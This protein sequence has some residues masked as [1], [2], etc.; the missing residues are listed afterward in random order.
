MKRICKTIVAIVATAGMCLG[1]YGQPFGVNPA[2]FNYF[3]DF[4][5]P[6]VK[7]L[8]QDLTPGPEEAYI[9]HGKPGDWGLGTRLTWADLYLP[10]Y[11]VGFDDWGGGPP[12]WWEYDWNKPKPG[13]WF[14]PYWLYCDSL[15]ETARKLKQN[16]RKPVCVLF[17]WDMPKFLPDWS[18]GPPYPARYVSPCPFGWNEAFP[19]SPPHGVQIRVYTDFDGEV[20]PE[21]YMATFDDDVLDTVF[22]WALAEKALGEGMSEGWLINPYT[23]TEEYNRWKTDMREMARELKRA[24]AEGNI[25]Y[26]IIGWLGAPADWYYRVFCWEP[27]LEIPGYPNRAD[28][29]VLC[30]KGAP[31]SQGGYGPP[32]FIENPDATWAINE[33]HWRGFD[34]VDPPG[35]Q[36]VR[37]WT[38]IVLLP[39]TSIDT[40][41]SPSDTVAVVVVHLWAV[42]Y[43][44]P[45]PD[46]PPNSAAP[47]SISDTFVLVVS[48]EFRDWVV[49]TTNPKWKYEWYLKPLL[50]ILQDELPGVK[51]VVWLGEQNAGYHGGC[52]PEPGGNRP[53]WPGVQRWHLFYGWLRDNGID[54]YPGCWFWG[55]S[56]RSHWM[57]DYPGHSWPDPTGILDHA[58]QLLIQTGGASLIDGISFNL[59]IC[60]WVE[61]WNP[62]DPESD[63][64]KRIGPDMEQ[65]AAFNDSLGGKEILLREIIPPIA[66]KSRDEKEAVSHVLNENSAP[67]ILFLDSPRVSGY[68]LISALRGGF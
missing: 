31:E 25:D 36:H 39:D 60:H 61:N 35:E 23:Q 2:G 26:F 1:F 45:K 62:N 42:N 64:Y 9:W 41:P 19:V 22:H 3:R 32:I 52:M 44:K 48:S 65:I 28:S 63:P 38:R 58:S 20:P 57:L 24:G 29:I 10:R 15:V 33:M 8:W 16:G 43:W 49:S 5:H 4:P 56:M 7:T 6:N 55:D 40:I 14:P 18:K 34:P 37:F 51:R 12:A 13:Y 30:G 11:A 59:Y 66:G 50:E 21:Y 54:G 47:P 67:L 53:Y 46:E 17:S 27:P 68:K